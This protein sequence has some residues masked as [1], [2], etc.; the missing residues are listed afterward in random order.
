MNYSNSSNFQVK[1]F[2]LKYD[3][4]ILIV[5]YNKLNDY[6]RKTYVRHIKFK[7]ISVNMTTAEELTMKI[8]KTNSDLLSEDKVS[9]TQIVELIKLL[10]YTDIS[11]K[12]SI[13]EDINILLNDNIDL[14]K[15]SENDNIKA[16]ELM[17]IKF[18][19]NR[20]DS[21]DKNFQYDKRI[22][23]EKPQEVSNWDESDEE[24]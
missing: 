18:E 19:S 12:S 16:K 10:L 4:P 15:V 9:Y 1:K 17:N 5:E 13:N 8:M 23:F 3:P 6:S 2:A 21:N 14:N 24:D 20:L 11:N 7:N 22:D